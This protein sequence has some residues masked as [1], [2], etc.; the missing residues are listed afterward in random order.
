MKLEDIMSV[1]WGFKASEYDVTLYS[2]L[3]TY[4]LFMYNWRY[5]QEVTLKRR[6]LSIRLHPDV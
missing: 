1:I 3:Y 4:R 6:E 2:V 5:T